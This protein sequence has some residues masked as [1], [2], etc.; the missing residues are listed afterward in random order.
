MSNEELAWEA[1]GY[2]A[3]TLTEE[4]LET[5]ERYEKALSFIY[6]VRLNVLCGDY[7][8]VDLLGL[9]ISKA[10]SALNNTEVT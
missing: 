3:K 2:G 10:G 5:L 7:K 1:A 4:L 6:G 8:D 9:C